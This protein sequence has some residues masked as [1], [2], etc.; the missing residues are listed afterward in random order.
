[1]SFAWSFF[2]AR[3]ISTS[4]YGVQP[5]DPLVFVAMPLVLAA[6]ALIAVWLPAQRASRID[7]LIA[8]RYE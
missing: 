6:V 4:L 3:V 5:R 2:L 7:P 8:L 1:M